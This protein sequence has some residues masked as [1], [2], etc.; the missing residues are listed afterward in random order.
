MHYCCHGKHLEKASLTCRKAGEGRR[1]SSRSRLDRRRHL[2]LPDRRRRR[3]QRADRQFSA[4]LRQDRD[5]STRSRTT[6]GT[7]D[8]RRSRRAGTCRG[9]HGE[10]ES[11]RRSTDPDLGGGPAAPRRPCRPDRRLVAGSSRRSRMPRPDGRSDARPLGP[12]PPDRRSSRASRP[13]RGRQPVASARPQV[14]ESVKR[15]LEWLLNTK[16]CSPTCPTGSADL[17]TRC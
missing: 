1:S 11:D 12:R 13:R 7:H 9:E 8:V 14:R 17:T 10:S 15:D 3:R 16:Q 5:T 6:D 4:E 2:Q